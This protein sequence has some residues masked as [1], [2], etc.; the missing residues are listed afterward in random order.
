MSGAIDLDRKFLLG[1]VY[2]NRIEASEHLILY[3]FFLKG[4]LHNFDALRLEIFLVIILRAEVVIFQEISAVFNE[5]HE[6]FGS[7]QH[8]DQIVSNGLE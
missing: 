1:K 7:Y 6:I 4:I 8:R 2:V 5:F 3:S